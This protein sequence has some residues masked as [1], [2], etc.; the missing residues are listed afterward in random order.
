ML[1]KFLL[2]AILISNQALAAD[3]KTFIRCDEGA[4]ELQVDLDQPKIVRASIVDPSIVSYFTASGAFYR[5]SSRYVAGRDE[6]GN[7][8][9]KDRDLSLHFVNAQNHRIERPEDFVGIAGQAPR[10]PQYDETASHYLSSGPGNRRHTAHIFPDGD[11]IKVS[12]E[13]TQGGDSYCPNVRKKFFLGS[14]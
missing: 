2:I 4:L 5:D 9:W 11:G 1:R 3:L 7:I 8:I 14:G 12:I 6:H 10:S 13:M